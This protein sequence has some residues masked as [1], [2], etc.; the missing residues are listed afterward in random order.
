MS[1]RYKHAHK[2]HAVKDAGSHPPGALVGAGT[3]PGLSS[4]DDLLLGG[5]AQLCEQVPD[6]EAR[7]AQL[8]APLELD[9]AWQEGKRLP[10]LRARRR[11]VEQA[12][13][14]SRR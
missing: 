2:T 3:H 1:S 13:R 8:H 4:E 6:A 14:T 10:L 5:F 7:A 12:L 9:A 11:L